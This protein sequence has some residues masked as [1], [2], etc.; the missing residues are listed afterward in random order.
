LSNPALRADS[1]NS[2]GVAAYFVTSSTDATLVIDNKGTGPLF[3]ALANGVTS[4]RFDNTGKG[5]FNGGTQTSGADLAEFIPVTELLEL[6]DV[7]EIDPN[8]A[9]QFRRCATSGSQSVAGVISTKP[10]VSLGATNPAGGAGDVNQGP[11]LALAGRIPVKVTDEGGSIR[12]GDLLIASSTPG[13]AKRASKHPR[14]GSVV[15]KALGG[16][17]T[18]AGIVEMLVMLR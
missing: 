7:V 3:K 16:L 5:F 11:Q 14:T 12:P 17:K 10:G 8:Q 1:G 4:I 9:G 15:G 2:A 13:H 18:G 6:G